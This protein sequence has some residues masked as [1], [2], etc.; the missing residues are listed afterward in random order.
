MLGQMNLQRQVS[1]STVHDARSASSGCDYETESK[2]WVHGPCRASAVSIL[3]QSVSQLFEGATDSCS[4][5]PSLHSAARLGGVISQIFPVLCLPAGIFLSLWLLCSLIKANQL[6]RKVSSLP[7]AVCLT[8]SAAMPT[9][10]CTAFR[11]L[12]ALC[13]GCTVCMWEASCVMQNLLCGHQAL[14]KKGSGEG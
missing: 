4:R 6:M 5:D 12:S 14:C 8:P 13:C 10:H 11:L 7:A 2:Q 3:S 9:A 1:D